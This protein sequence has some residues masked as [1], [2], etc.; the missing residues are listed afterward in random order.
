MSFDEI[1]CFFLLIF[2]VI[3]SFQ[4]FIFNGTLY[5]KNIDEQTAYCRCLALCPTPRSNTEETYFE[6]GWI[7]VDGFVENLKHRSQLQLYQARFESNPITFVKQLSELRNNAQPPIMS[8]VGSII[9]NSV[10][11]IHGS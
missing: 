1:N 7:T 10:K 2:S 3:Q 5:F 6:K 11:L 9:L 4:L 8:H